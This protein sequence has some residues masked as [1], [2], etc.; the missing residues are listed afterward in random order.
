[1][2]HNYI[3]SKCVLDRSFLKQYC[4]CPH[5]WICDAIS[6]EQM[7]VPIPD[8]GHGAMDCKGSKNIIVLVATNMDRINA[9]ACMH[10]YKIYWFCTCMG[11]GQYVLLCYSRAVSRAVSDKSRQH[12][13]LFLQLFP[14]VAMV[15]MSGRSCMIVLFALSMNHLISSPM[16]GP[17]AP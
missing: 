16:S 14:C 9:C 4:W 2:W 10:A 12:Q 7:V 8:G 6:H 17:P 11:Q 15:W 3:T 13:P 5:I 1:M